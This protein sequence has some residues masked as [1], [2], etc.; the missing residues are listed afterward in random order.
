MTEPAKDI[1]SIYASYNLAQHQYIETTENET[2]Q[3]VKGKWLIFQSQRSGELE[4]GNRKKQANF[5]TQA[6]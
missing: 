5:E 2:Y 1:N 4:M 6:I 3:K